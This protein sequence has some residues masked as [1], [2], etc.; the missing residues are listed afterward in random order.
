MEAFHALLGTRPGEMVTDF[1]AR[2]KEE[3]GIRS[4]TDISVFGT[5]P[6]QERFDRERVRAGL[7]FK[8]QVPAHL[9]G[10]GVHTPGQMASHPG[11]GVYQIP[12][13]GTK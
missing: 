10:S 1:L 8:I 2:H 7:V 4:V 12:R 5:G 13:A 11:G 3:L 9:A 6:H